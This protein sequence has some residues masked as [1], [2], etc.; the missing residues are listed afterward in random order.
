MM[1]KLKNKE[2][3]SMDMVTVI[4]DIRKMM[5]KKLI[6]TIKINMAVI[7]TNTTKMKKIIDWIFENNI[8][9]T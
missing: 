5:L 3:K 9:N 6:I 1:K 2:D 7:T 4:K 8:N